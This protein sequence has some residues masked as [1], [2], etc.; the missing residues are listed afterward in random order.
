[1]SDVFGPASLAAGQTLSSFTTFLPRLSEVRK[2]NVEN[3]T[4]MVGDVRL[5]EVAAC[6]IS[7]GIGVIASSL[8]GS[9]VPMYAAGF[10]AVIL[11]CVYESAL[12]GNSLF[13]PKTVEKVYD[14]A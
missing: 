7:L 1:M 4:G 11:I 13:E 8:S 5:G 3:D 6:A 2:A 10:M 9:P 14:N 12:R